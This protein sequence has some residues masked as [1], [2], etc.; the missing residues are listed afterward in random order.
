MTGENINQIQKAFIE[1]AANIMRE[2]KALSDD[3]TALRKE[4]TGQGFKHR[5]I[6]KSAKV[7]L[8][9]NPTMAADELRTEIAEDLSALDLVAPEQPKQE[10]A[11]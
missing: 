7:L 2:Q 8:A 6:K 4:L 10:E 1:R 9:K 3:M 5:A 11:A